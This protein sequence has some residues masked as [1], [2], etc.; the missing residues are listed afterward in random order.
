[1]ITGV[2]LFALVSHF[3]VLPNA[4]K[5]GHLFTPGTSR[6]L[7]AISLA[8]CGLSFLLLKAMPRRSAEQ[9]ADE[10][11]GTA[12]PFAIRVWAPLEGASLA[13]VVDYSHGGGAASIAVALLAV[14]LFLLLN[15]SYLESR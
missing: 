3:V 4:T 14:A 13:A 6:I 2:V 5:S 10:F 1:M 15:P 11:W 8:S 7:L 9:T 12:A